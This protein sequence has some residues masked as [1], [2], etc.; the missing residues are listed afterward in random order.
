[1][2]KKI[3]VKSDGTMKY[4]SKIIRMPEWYDSKVPLAFSVML[5]FLIIYSQEDAAKTVLNLFLYFVFLFSY[6]AFNYLLN[7][8]IDM[9]V[10]RKA[11]KDKLIT[12]I[13]KSRVMCI[14]IFLLITGFL[15]LNII[16]GF[17]YKMAFVLIINYLFGASYHVKPLRFK[18]RGLLG[19]IVSSAAQRCTPLLVIPLLCN[20]S[21]HFFIGWIML[22][23][24]NGLR[25]ILIHQYKDY[26]ADLQSGVK[27]FAIKHRKG[28]ILEIGVYLCFAVELITAFYLLLPLI[29]LYHLIVAVILLYMA[30]AVSAMW[31]IRH[32]IKE[33]VFLTFTYVPLED[34]FNV[35]QPL[36]FAVLLTIITQSVWYMIVLIALLFYLLPTIKNKCALIF[37]P[38]QVKISGAKFN[39][40]DEKH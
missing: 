3:L 29:F 15:P 10:D 35:I 7:D 36:L 26:N 23:F 13:P 6:L 9:E 40:G 38:L 17:D 16:N 39:K 31:A 27:T 5:F 11:G 2:D 21:I 25:Y 33:K 28:K 24:L 4:I 20:I 18:E 34:F 37:L 30:A 12:K 22:S 19:L 8:Y 32:F 1:M 14:M